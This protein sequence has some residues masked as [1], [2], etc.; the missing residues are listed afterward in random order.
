V[1]AG[2]NLFLHVSNGCGAGAS[3]SIRPSEAATITKVA[4]AQDGR[5]A[6]AVI[7]PHQTRFGVVLQN[8]ASSGSG[9]W[10]SFLVVPVA[11]IWIGFMM[12][13]RSA[14]RRQ[15]AAQTAWLTSVGVHQALRKVEKR[16]D[17]ARS[18]DPSRERQGSEFVPAGPVPSP[19]PFGVSHE[20]AEALV[21]QWIRYLGEPDATITRFSRDGGVDVESTH[22]IAQVKNYSGTVGVTQMRELGGVASVDGRNRSSLLLE[23]TLRAPLSSRSDSALCYS[24][25][26][27][28]TERSSAPTPRVDLPFITACRCSKHRTALASAAR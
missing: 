8:A 6:A 28:R 7:Q 22:Y 13:W 2:L 25:M 24:S 23:H 1:S 26:T 9:T 19:Q 21:A 20:G 18:Y 4:R 15:R 14:V 10:S 3:V 27:P 12:A 17:Q 16:R 11:L 5:I